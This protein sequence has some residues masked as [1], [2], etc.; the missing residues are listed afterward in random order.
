[1][2][3]RKQ[4]TEVKDRHKE[5]ILAKPNVLGVGTGYKYQK[6]TQVGDLCLVA[7]VSQKIPRAGLDP[8]DLVPVEVEGIATDVIQVG[9]LR[10]HQERTDRW[11]PALGGVSLG[12]YRV[13]AGTLGVV[14]RDRRTN[15]RLILSNNHVLANNNQ[16]QAGDAIVQPGAA[17]G[18]REEKDTFASLER[19]C[20]I[21]FSLGPVD[22]RTAEAYASFGNWMAKILG[23]KHR[24]QAYWSDPQATNQIDAAV[25]RPVDEL[26]VLDEILEIGAISGVLPARLG[27]R[28]RK[29]GRTT[30]VTMGQIMVLDATVTIDYGG[31]TARFEDQIVTT[32]MSQPGD[33]GSLLVAAE[34]LQAVGLLFA[35]SDQVTLHNPIQAVLD[36]LDVTL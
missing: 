9:F 2:P 16:G 10:A 15:D 18:G 5:S 19:F 21:N 31:R 11:R 36:Y 32:V 28:V 14:V 22:C 3:E 25:A 34:S 26:D 35:G 6:G 4:V 27:M 33:S 1:M 20:P 29:S 17:D 7:M 23:S 13:T 24:V 8:S 30:G 12:H